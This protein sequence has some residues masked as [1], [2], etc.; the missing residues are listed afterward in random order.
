MKTYTIEQK[1]S[2]TG[3]IHDIASDNFDR[4]IEF[5]GAAKYAVVLASYYG[6]KGY[7]THTT[8][9]SA[10]RQAHKLGKQNY[11]YEIIDVDGTNY[12]SNGGAHYA[13]DRLIKA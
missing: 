4:V 1:M 10:C 6:G 11:S 7:T 5:R 13:G 12:Q 8:E 2:N 3:S 9:E